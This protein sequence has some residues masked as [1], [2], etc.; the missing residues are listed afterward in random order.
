[1][2]KLIVPLVALLLVGGGGTAA[3]TTLHKPARPASAAPVH[4]EVSTLVSLPDT[5][6]NLRGDDGFSY[7][8]V[9]ISVLV[10]GPGP[11]ETLKAAADARKSALRDALN[12]IVEGQ[13]FTALR[14]PDGRRALESTLRTRFDEILAPAHADT[15]YFEEFVAE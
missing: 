6:I 7:L 13:A 4:P 10:K 15:V 3:W 8:R 14:T 11:E 12:A 2:K 5:T 9:Q 1:M